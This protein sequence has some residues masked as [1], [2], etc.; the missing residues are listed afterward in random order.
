MN[1]WRTSSLGARGSVA[2]WGTMLEGRRFESQMRWIFSIYQIL[3]AALWPWGVKMGRR[4][5]LTTLPQS[6]IL[7]SENVGASI[8]RNPKGLQCMYREKFTFTFYCIIV[9]PFSLSPISD[10]CKNIWSVA[11]RLRRN[12]CWW[13]PT[14]LSTYGLNLEKMI[15]DKL[16]YEVDE[17]DVP[18]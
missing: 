1:S 12:P 7:L 11:D 17:S 18:R 3:P 2:G 6:V 9:L 16:L 15:L 13:S 14:I 8:S 4:V 10:E 5:G